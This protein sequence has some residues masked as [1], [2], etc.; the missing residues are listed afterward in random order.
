MYRL[1]S[2]GKHRWR[3]EELEGSTPSAGTLSKSMPGGRRGN[4]T[5]P[6]QL[7]L[8]FC[9]QVQKWSKSKVK[10]LF[11][12][13]C[14]PS[15]C[16]CL[17][18]S[19]G[20]YRASVFI[21]SWAFMV[22]KAFYKH[23]KWFIELFLPYGRFKR[24]R[25]VPHNMIRP[26]GSMVVDS[27]VPV[28]L[29]SLPYHQP[30]SAV[31]QT[32]VQAEAQPCWGGIVFQLAEPAKHKAKLLNINRGLEDVSCSE[33]FMKFI[34]LNAAEVKKQLIHGSIK[35]SPNSREPMLDDFLI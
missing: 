34:L 32:Q 11:F 8:P 28:P 13:F 15:C 12:F 24:K 3:K 17:G 4:G 22:T 26:T 7:P 16:L 27:F 1:D 20:K 14:K 18:N 33:R 19:C 31:T 21:I 30:P 10:Q 2:R 25:D 35:A 5:A 23:G 6:I 29:A 9:W